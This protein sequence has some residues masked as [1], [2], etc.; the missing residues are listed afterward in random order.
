MKCS[1]F[2]CHHKLALNLLLLFNVV[3]LYGGGESIIYILNSNQFGTP[4]LVHKKMTTFYN[5]S[6]LSHKKR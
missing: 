2:R 3:T 6:R 1:H 5:F 4:S